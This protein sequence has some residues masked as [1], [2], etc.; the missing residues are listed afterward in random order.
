MNILVTGGFGFIGRSL[1]SRLL[2]EGHDV[3]V[4]CRISPEGY[5]WKNSRSKFKVVVGDLLN[6][7]ALEKAT[8]GIEQVF[9]LASS[10]IPGTSNYHIKADIQSDLMGTINLLNKCVKNKIKKICYISSGGSIYGNSN[11]PP[12]NENAEL[13]PLNSYGILKLTIEKYLFLYF[14]LYGLNYIVLRI[15]NVYG[16]GGILKPGFSAVDTFIQNF[17]ANKEIKIFGDGSITRDYIYID[18]VVSAI[19]KA[20]NYSGK[21]NIFNIGTGIGTSLNELLIIIQSTLFST[22]PINFIESRPSDNLINFLD[23]SK[24]KNILKWESNIDLIDG[25]KKT[26]ELRLLT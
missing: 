26:I 7:E 8:T 6:E 2:E 4:L 13:A 1:V 21:E 19:V 9:H 16:N 25:I 20:L 11:S 23:V 17:I 5:D 18:D 14:H 24:A 22:S 15:S 10:S 3:V 12:I